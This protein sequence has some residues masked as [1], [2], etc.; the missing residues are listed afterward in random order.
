VSGKQQ[1]QARKADGSGR[2]V[3]VQSEP[4]GLWEGFWSADS[5]WLVYRTDDVAAGNGDIYARRTRGDTTPVALLE[6]VAT[7]QSPALSP[8]GRWLAYVATSDQ[9]VG[10]QVYVRPFPNVGDGIWLVSTG[11]GTEPVWSHDGK[12]L[13]Y[14][15]LSD[16]MMM[17]A[18][19]AGAPTF[20][21]LR[22][23]P[24]FSAA[25]YMVDAANR[26]YAVTP[27]D[28]HF[29]MLRPVP[30]KADQGEAGRYVLVE[31][32]LREVQEKLRQ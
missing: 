9:S 26:Y 4:R 22:R 31:H 28:R 16:G 3:D 5:S 30:E 10:R 13:F 8:D 27:D 2:P 18:D 19:V 14:R 11:G 25:E 32:W 12:T 29:I 21:V 6:T 23:I 15:R 24:L 7:E 1:L 17:A 20:A